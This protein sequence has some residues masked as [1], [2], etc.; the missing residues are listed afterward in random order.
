MGKAASDKH[1]EDNII[2]DSNIGSF[3]EPE[4]SEETSDNISKLY[5]SFE[6]RTNLN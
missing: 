5:E 3:I 2:F 4:Y 1:E 6:M